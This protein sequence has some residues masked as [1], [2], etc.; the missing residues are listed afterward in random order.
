MAYCRR[1]LNRSEMGDKT[2]AIE[3]YTRA[4]EI[5]PNNA[6]AYNNRGFTRYSLGD[7]HGAI[8]DYMKAIRINP[9][10]TLAYNNLN[11]ARSPKKEQDNAECVEAQIH[12]A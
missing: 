2:G 8:Q 1:G 9:K 6:Y 12:P 7:K 5:E 4:I 11:I 10:Y 3:D